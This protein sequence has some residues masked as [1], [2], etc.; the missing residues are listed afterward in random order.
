[1]DDM[2]EKCAKICERPFKR[3][4]PSCIDIDP[5]SSEPVNSLISQRELFAFFN[6]CMQIRADEIRALK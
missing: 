3:L 2:V 5:N 4:A 1:M 6:V